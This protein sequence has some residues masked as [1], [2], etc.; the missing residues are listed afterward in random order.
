MDR[1]NFITRVPPVRRRRRDDKEM[2]SLAQPTARA[3]SSG[4]D[5]CDGAFELASPPALC[6]L[7][8]KQWMSNVPSNCLQDGYDDAR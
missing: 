8:S 3:V 4:G 7:T 2:V 5:R 1:E 6:E